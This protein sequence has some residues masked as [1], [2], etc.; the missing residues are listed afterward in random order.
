MAEDSSSR[1]GVGTIGALW[2]SAD[3]S[4]VGNVATFQQSSTITSL[5]SV[6]TGFG[7][8]GQN[9]VMS[10]TVASL[11]SVNTGFSMNAG[12]N[13]LLP[14]SSLK[15]VPSGFSLLSSSTGI[16]VI[17]AG[18]DRTQYFGFGISGTLSVSSI[19]TAT[20]PLRNIGSSNQFLSSWQPT[21]WQEIQI[22]IGAY[23]IFGGYVNTVEQT[24]Y[25]NSSSL[26]LYTVNCFAYGSLL[27]RVFVAE[28]FELYDGAL[29]NIIMYALVT[30]Y[31]A[32]R[33][34][35]W[36]GTGGD[37]GPLFPPFDINYLSFTQTC[38]YV[39]DKGNWSFYVDQW[40]VLR[41][42]GIASV[43]RPAP[44]TLSKTNSKF[45]TLKP[46]TG[47][48]YYNSVIVRNSA[49]TSAKWT[50]T[51]A[52]NANSGSGFYAP[53]RASLTTKP[54]VLV[55]GVAA[56]VVDPGSYGKPWD[57]YWLNF[58]VQRNPALAPLGGGDTVSVV[59]LSSLSF[60]V[61][62]KSSTEIATYGE[63]QRLFELKN[64]VSLSDMQIISDGLLAKGIAGVTALQA[65]TDTAGIEP[66]Q[67]LTVSAS[68][69]SDNYMVEE[70]SFQQMA[71]DFFRFSIKASN[72]NVQRRDSGSALFQKLLT[73]ALQPKDR[74][75]TPV[76]FNLWTTVAG[77]TNPGGTGGAYI[78]G[79]IRNMPVS[80]VCIKCTLDFQSVKSGS[81]VTT[82]DVIIDVQINRVSIFPAG[83]PA[84]MIFPAGSTTPQE[85]IIFLN[86]PES[87]VI[88]QTVELY[89][90]QTDPNAYDGVLELTVQTVT[91]G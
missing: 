23:L 80:G 59:Y 78:P 91:V 42:F 72:A 81:L 84:K 82:T 46:T 35:L 29:A 43:G 31:L 28:H 48:D 18:V 11:K 68:P 45:E 14:V 88:N 27:D 30:K 44:F 1:V 53:L 86:D 65:D 7:F 6:N 85:V 40:K 52:G 49:D 10:A 79:A 77:L 51:F 58:G 34:F 20:L 47:G 57:F 60:V 26:E 63:F 69:V 3:D 76:G 71:P 32:A 19:G 16:K 15:S 56:K 87:V 38:Q 24:L 67:I 75:Q 54:V 2:V 83:N 90:I 8:G 36:G 50:D 55:N 41:M 17:V 13:M 21:K 62:S 12:M 70:V 39:A 61:T 5:S 9:F 33:G 74:V 22:W 25:Q 89:C 73:Q 37:V 66:G 4:T 64:F